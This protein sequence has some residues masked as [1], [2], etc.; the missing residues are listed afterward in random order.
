MN[1]R[2]MTLIELT[3]AMAI[4]TVVS[5]VLMMLSMSIGDTTQIR[6]VKVINNDEA[7]QALQILVPMIRQ[8]AKAT[9]NTGAL[10]G[11]E[12]TFQMATDVDGNGSAVNVNGEI[13][14]GAPVT[15]Q[16]D[17]DDLN[18]DGLTLGQL[19]VIQGGSVIRVLAN[20]LTPVDESTGQDGVLD[21]DEDLNNNGRLDRGF[22]VQPQ[23]NGLRVTVGTQGLARRGHVICTNYSEFVIARN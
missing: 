1:N 18:G 2:G 20:S 3:M 8:S 15:V 19:V 7:R 17:K 14:L 9:I 21:D 13:E 6:E 10:P 4:F 11:G 16:R 12:L 23:G 5:G 22:W